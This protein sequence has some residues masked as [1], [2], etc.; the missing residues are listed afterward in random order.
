MHAIGYEDSVISSALGWLSIQVSGHPFGN[1]ESFID[2]PAASSRECNHCQAPTD[3]PNVHIPGQAIADEGAN[4]VDDS[5]AGSTSSRFWQ[6]LSPGLHGNSSR[7]ARH[8]E[9]G[10]VPF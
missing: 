2:L 10:F 3:L 1:E 6:W 4:M 5:A 9:D 7:V 8:N